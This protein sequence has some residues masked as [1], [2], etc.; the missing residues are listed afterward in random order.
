MRDPKNQ[1]TA[2][3]AHCT[4][5]SHNEKWVWRV[6]VGRERATT[7]PG[8]TWWGLKLDFF[9]RWKTNTLGVINIKFMTGLHIQQWESLKYLAKN[10]FYCNFPTADDDGGRERIFTGE[11]LISVKNIFLLCVCVVVGKGSENF[12]NSR[13]ASNFTLTLVCARRVKISPPSPSVSRENINEYLAG[14]Y[15]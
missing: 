14:F 6:A 7:T 8:L 10:L 3:A 15:A 11:N 1:L 5:F 12:S 4:K 13:T 2:A 9:E